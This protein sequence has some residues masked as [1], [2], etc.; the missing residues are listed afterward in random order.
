MLR[1]TFVDRSIG[2]FLRTPVVAGF[3]TVR[4]GRSQNRIATASSPRV[5]TVAVAGLNAA[6]SALR[7]LTTSISLS[8]IGVG[9]TLEN[10]GSER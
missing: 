9:E 10:L 6:T 8:F 1:R 7:N 5:A 3:P 2:S 4:R